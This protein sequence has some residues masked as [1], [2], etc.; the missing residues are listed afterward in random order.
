M[1]LHDDARLTKDV[2][3]GLRD[4]IDDHRDLH[5]RVTDALAVDLDG[6][7]FVLT[8][9]QPVF[10]A[11]DGA[12]HLTWPIMVASSLAGKPFGGTPRCPR[13]AP[14]SSIAGQAAAEN[15]VVKRCTTSARAS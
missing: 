7:G 10:L 12:G 2:D 8:A 1:R 4:D 5:D 3:L 13:R 6:D 9:S 11:A 14:T 15:A